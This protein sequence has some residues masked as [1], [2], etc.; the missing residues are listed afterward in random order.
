V[1]G[2]DLH[3]PNQKLS[4]TEL[5][6]IRAQIERCWTFDPGGKDL[7]NMIAPITVKLQQDGTVTSAE[8]TGDRT[9]Y[10]TDSTYRAFVESARRSV[11][12]C[13]PLKAPPTKYDTWKELTFRF[14]PKGMLGR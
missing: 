4:M 10:A 8:F 12:I 13:S 14:D 9:R 11:L 2:S 1:R 7:R 6:M 3:D 5:D